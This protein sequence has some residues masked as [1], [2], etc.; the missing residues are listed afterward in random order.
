MLEH[1]LKYNIWVQ[2]KFA[3]P[4]KMSKKNISMSRPQIQSPV[5]YETIAK[6]LIFFLWERMSF[7]ILFYSIQVLDIIWR[8]HHKLILSIC[9]WFHILLKQNSKCSLC[10]QLFRINRELEKCCTG[11]ADTQEVGNESP[12][13]EAHLM[14]FSNADM[15]VN[16]E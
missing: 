8:I 14:V 4:Q 12:L 7:T 6:W 1:L 5:N 15:S 13:L 16:K 9:N 3:C 11:R 10:L 2:L